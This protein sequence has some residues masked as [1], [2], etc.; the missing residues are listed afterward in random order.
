MK[1]GFLVIGTNKYR[2]LALDLLKSIEQKFLPNFSR[3]IFIFSDKDIFSKKIKNCHF[4]KIHHENWPLTSLK[5]FEYI[6]KNSEQINQ[7]E[8]LFYL[9][10]DLLV[11]E[12]INKFH[13]P[14]LFAV[15]HPGNHLDQNF[16][17]VETNEE[18]TAYLN[19]DIRGHYVQGCFWG[20]KT[21][22]VLDM[23]EVLYHNYA[24]DLEK[25][26]IA[27]WYDESHLNR[28]F[29]DNQE[30]TSTV[31]SSYSYPTGYDLPI[32]KIILHREKNSNK[33]RS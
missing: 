8:Y 24:I 31:S 11:V 26:I 14:A 2:S 4:I 7:C 29:F 13:F 10:A 27:K 20:G 21:K 9:D 12:S 3:R 16:W 33:L 32:E 19:P 17:D 15:S 1:V 25:G 5:R 22:N 28:Y 30:I 6:L 23:C 18:S